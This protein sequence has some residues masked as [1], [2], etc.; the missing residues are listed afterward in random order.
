VPCNFKLQAVGVPKRMT[1]HGLRHTTA[2][3]LLMAGVPIAMVSRM[4]RHSSIAVTE[5]IYAHLAPD[6]LHEQLQRMSFQPRLVETPRRDLPN[7]EGGKPSD[8]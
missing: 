4:L 8:V 3:L 2:S 1:F 6:W 5:R 7:A